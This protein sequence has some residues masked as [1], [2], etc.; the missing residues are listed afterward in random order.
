MR[1]FS[2][3]K[4]NLSLRILGKRPDGFHEVETLMAPLDFGDYVEVK[5][6]REPGVNIRC[7]TPDIPLGPENLVWKALAAFAEASAT[8]LAYNVR[9]EKDIPA[10]AGLGGGSSNAATA[11]VSA[12]RL[13][14]SPLELA[15]LIQV[16]GT[17]GSDVAFFC[18]ESWAWCRGRGE[19]IEPCEAP[20]RYRV[21]LL[22]PPF[23]VSTPWAYKNWA[24]TAHLPSPEAQLLDDLAL[25]NDLE[26]PV[27]AKYLILN[28]MKSWL[29]ARP[30]VAA[31]M[32]SGSGST[33]FAI[34]RPTLTEAEV[35]ELLSA[36]REEFGTE[37]WMQVAT[38]SGNHSD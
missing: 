4:I 30:G 38:T 5:I 7:E 17:I 9:L 13:N 8:P 24:A 18:A 23:P 11:L 3:A 1:S 21:L 28:H 27:F 31:A 37:T 33:M 10:G 35:T 16:A 34:L 20:G 25:V 6:R 19:L 15:E 36:A 12:N 26:R 14:G 29:R 2:P 32:M 22:K